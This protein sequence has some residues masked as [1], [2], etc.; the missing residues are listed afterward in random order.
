MAAS[1]RAARQDKYDEPGQRGRLTGAV[2]PSNVPLNEYG[3]EDPDAFFASPTSTINPASTRKHVGSSRKKKAATKTDANPEGARRQPRPDRGHELGEVGRKTGARIKGVAKDAQGVE[4]VEEFFK[5]PPPTAGR[6][7]RDSD[8]SS[9]GV[10]RRESMAADSSARRSRR[11]TG[12]SV[13][14][15]ADETG[16]DMD[17][18]D[19]VLPSH[20][21][22]GACLTYLHFRYCHVSTRI[23]LSRLATHSA[24]FNRLDHL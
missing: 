8:E 17:L 19:G 16:M 12:W 22:V 4:S 5:S 7:R 13:V 6:I 9:V 11:E 2:M 10:G 14:N 18:Q 24:P 21:L 1:R 20:R 23:H 3:A 15:G